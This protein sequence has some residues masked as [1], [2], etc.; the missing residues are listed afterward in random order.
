MMEEFI[1]TVVEALDCA[2][3]ISLFGTG[4]EAM[5]RFCISAGSKLIYATSLVP[6]NV[7]VNFHHNS[8][9]TNVS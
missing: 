4:L 2:W 8:H 5:I 7:H 6:I 9:T 1:S 3:V